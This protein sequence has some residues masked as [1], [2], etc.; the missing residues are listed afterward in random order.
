MPPARRKDATDVTAPPFGW[1]IAGTGAIARRFVADMRFAGRGRVV[2]I[3]SASLER[4]RRLAAAVGPD[5][6]A[7]DLDAIL[8]EPE[9]DA[10]YI[11]GRNEDHC[12]QALRC[13][14]AGKPVLIEKPVATAAGDV[15]R[16]GRAAGD[17]GLLAMEAMWMRFTPG[18][19]RLKSLVDAGAVGTVRAVEATLSFR[20]VAPPASTL[21]D[22]GVYPVSLAVQLLGSP[23]G[24]AAAAAGSDIGFV[25]SYP[26]AVAAFRCG[27]GTEGPNVLSVTGDAGTIA[28]DAPFFCPS[29]LTIRPVAPAGGQRAEAGTAEAPVGRSRLPWL[30][31]A[32]ALL[33][34]LRMRRIPTLYRGTGLQ[35]QADHFA[36]CLAAGLRD[37]PVMPFAESGEVIRIVEAVEAALDRASPY[38]ANGSGSKLVVG[39]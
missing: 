2:G 5:V 17:A 29:L 18:M 1:A 25:L 15:E 21:L 14:S 3:A 6:V 20:N 24:I 27:Y 26:N 8:R 19:R 22:L 32:K 35:Y 37:S 33:R 34:P 12:P 28:T 7:G 13:L 39:R 10:V 9:V 36:E 31:A 4:A 11:A 23:T 30:G 16:I 38:S